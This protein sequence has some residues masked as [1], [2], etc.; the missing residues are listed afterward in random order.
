MADLSNTEKEFYLVLHD[1]RIRSYRGEV[2]YFPP[3]ETI[4]T[5][6]L[7]EAYEAL[8]NNDSKLPY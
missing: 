5:Y 3:N 6:N 1:W 8:R 2:A 7:N 4:G